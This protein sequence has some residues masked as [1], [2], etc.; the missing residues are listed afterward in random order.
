MPVHERTLSV[1]LGLS[2]IGWAIAGLTTDGWSIVRTALASLQVVVGVLFLLRMP[3]IRI[4][5]LGQLG[6]AVPSLIISGLAFK[7][8]PDDWAMA[9]S[10]LFAVGSLSAIASLIVLGRSF[11]VLPAVRRVVTSG[12][13]RFVRHPIYLS[14]LV[15]VTACCLAESSWLRVGILVL[16]IASLVWRIRAEEDLLSSTPNYE[17]YA[18]QR[19]WRLLPGIW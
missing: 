18:E 11:A 10:V 7:L 17:S 12:P 19:R 3:Q 16:A 1:G 14:E 2:C 9:W 15:M 6:Q 8:R 4:G 13:Y 5:T